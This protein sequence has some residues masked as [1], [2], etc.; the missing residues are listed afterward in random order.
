M[1]CLLL[2]SACNILLFSASDAGAFPLMQQLFGSCLRDGIEI[3]ADKQRIFQI[4]FEMHLEIANSV[5]G[6]KAELPAT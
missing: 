4:P 3:P 1:S 5:P 6:W 2:S